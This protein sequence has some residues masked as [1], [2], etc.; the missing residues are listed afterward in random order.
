M[1][2]FDAVGVNEIMERHAE[3]VMDLEDKQAK[4]LIKKYRE[5][6][7]ELRDRLDAFPDGTFTSQQLRGILTQVDAAL[8]A[9]QDRL[10]GGMLEASDVIAE[11]GIRQ[12]V[13]ELEA[14]EGIFTG[15]VVPINLNAVLVGQDTKNFLINR[16]EAS[17]AAYSQDLRA[18]L[19]NQLTNSMIAEENLSLV[20]RRLG[21]YFLGEEWKLLRI[22]RTE[23]HNVYNIAKL[24]SYK[25]VRANQLP[26]LKKSLYHPMDHRTG[27]DS[28]ALAEENPIVDVDKPFR[29][30]FNGKKYVFM[31]PPNRPNDRAVLIPYRESWNKSAS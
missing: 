4:F 16:Y 18:D 29:Q 10:N 22:A 12:A 15:A 17:I 23:L 24:N 8:L 27:K 5:I 25:E 3:Q 26:D 2:F 9:M 13:G 7:Q 6:R 1:S 21:R 30:T 28:L 20:V 19:T 11:E 14:F 31:A